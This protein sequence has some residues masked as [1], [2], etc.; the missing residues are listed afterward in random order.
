LAGASY[1]LQLAGGDQLASPA[2]TLVV[3]M[4]AG[5]PGTY[6]SQEVTFGLK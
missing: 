6:V 2:D 4:P 1:E 3:K 5:A